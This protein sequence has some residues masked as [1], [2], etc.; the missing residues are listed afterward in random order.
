MTEIDVRQLIGEAA[1]LAAQ[2]AGQI[3][4]P[5]QPS[6]LPAQGS[7]PSD[8]ARVTAL[9][10]LDRLMRI[11]VDAIDYWDRAQSGW[12]Y[13]QPR[14]VQAAGVIRGDRLRYGR[15]V[16]DDPLQ[17][18]RDAGLLAGILTRT[19]A[20]IASSPLYAH[21]QDA[22]EDDLKWLA[23]KVRMLEVREVAQRPRHCQVCG[24]RDVWADLTHNSGVCAGCGAV[25]RAEVW[26]SVREAA[27]RLGVS[28]RTVQS[29]VAGGAVESRKSGRTSQVEWSEC[30]E[31]QELA[32]A[33]RKLNLKVGS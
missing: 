4:P 2:L 24:V 9:H 29:W 17:A 33:R 18:G 23:R 1:D 25:M 8:A 12:E 6:D 15:V 3:I 11:L 20:D 14:D 13:V 7:D 30:R 31:H 5:S 28:I 16:T 19:W 22:T 21:W 10:D 26:L 27:K 32:E